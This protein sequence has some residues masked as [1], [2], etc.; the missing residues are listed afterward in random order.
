MVEDR[1]KQEIHLLDYFE[2]LVRYRWFIVRNFLV[3]VLVVAL[4]SLVLPPKYV[5]VA[6]LMPPQEQSKSSMESLLAEV[7]VPGLPL[8]TASSSSSD[9]MVEILK[10]RSVGERV[11][12]RTFKC[13]D[14]S[15]PLYKCLKFP[16]VQVGLLKMKRKVRFNSS[17]QGIISIAVELGDRQLA[18]DV[19]NAYVEELDR[20]NQEKNVS[21]AKNSRIYLESQL[22]QTQKKLSEASRK[23]AD[24]RAKYKAVSLEE[25]MKVAIQTA[26]ELKGQMIAK[27][28]QIG[29]MLQTMKPQNPLVIRAQKE[30]EELRRRYYELQDGVGGKQAQ[31]SEFY[32]PF[33]QVPEIGLQLAELAREAKVQE[34]VWEL[35]NQQYYQAKIQEARDTPTIQ[36]LDPA[37]PPIVRSSP[38]RKLLVIVF[39]ALSLLVSIVWIYGKEY[40]K[41][42]DKRPE[43][44]KTLLRIKSELATD[45]V[46]F[47]NKLKI[48]NK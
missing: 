20:I 5:A 34:T 45:W 21:R 27:E 48:T 47:K 3:T 46:R 11:L 2:I 17:P 37:V 32:L 12:Q 7:S 14:D 43:E 26:G 23:L 40:A 31:E 39:G 30:L 18:A 38:K 24:F 16:S 36:V 1:K 10:S 35:L 22:Q 41:D 15:L 8:P 29:V 19:A 33:D 9:V 25:Q 44:K 28:V 42:L 4:I 13:D 6:T